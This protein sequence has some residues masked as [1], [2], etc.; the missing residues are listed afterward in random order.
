MLGVKQGVSMA[1]LPTA[2]EKA[3]MAL[4][5]FRR[6]NK[7]AGDVVQING[8]ISVAASMK[9]RS[10]EIAEGIEH[11]MNLGWFEDAGNGSVRL[12]QKG[13]AEI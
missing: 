9:L 5:V 10:E 6:L 1:T 12:T 11:G 2:E 4:A 3:R 13:F 8:F 7:R